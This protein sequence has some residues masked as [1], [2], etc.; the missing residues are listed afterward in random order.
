MRLRSKVLLLKWFLILFF[1]LRKNKTSFYVFW[2]SCQEIYLK[3]SDDTG[4]G[5]RIYAF[6]GIS[7]SAFE[8]LLDSFDSVWWRP[9]KCFFSSVDVLRLTLH[10]MNSNMRPKH[11]CQVVSVTQGFVS[12]SLDIGLACLHKCLL[13]SPA[14]DRMARRTQIIFMLFIFVFKCFWICTMA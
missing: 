9:R 1:K 6:P 2:A 10:W 12:Y 11:L 14:G 7:R 8:A 3:S 4:Q 5:W 13:T